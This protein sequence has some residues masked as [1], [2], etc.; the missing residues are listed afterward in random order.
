MALFALVGCSRKTDCVIYV[1]DD[2]EPVYEFVVTRADGT[3]YGYVP[4]KPGVIRLPHRKFDWLVAAPGFRFG[5]VPAARSPATQRVTVTLRPGLPVRL[6]VP[7]N[8]PLPRPPHTLI[9]LLE[10]QTGPH[11]WA[12]RYAIGRDKNDRASAATDREGNRKLVIREP[13]RAVGVLVPASG[14]YRVSVQFQRYDAARETVASA[15]EAISSGTITIQPRAGL[16]VFSVRPDA[17]AY[18]AAL[19]RLR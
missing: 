17:Q 11:R 14:S 1:N 5:L 2:G 3:G 10:R 13:R 18:E 7:R 16:Q 12:D 4:R 8:I 19:A 15:G 9:V 6:E